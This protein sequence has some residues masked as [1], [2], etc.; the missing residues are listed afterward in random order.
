M[1]NHN[2]ITNVSTKLNL[3][4]L[5]FLPAGEGVMVG[6]MVAVVGLRPIDRFDGRLGF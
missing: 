1:Y 2:V 3:K 6:A 5:G 4:A